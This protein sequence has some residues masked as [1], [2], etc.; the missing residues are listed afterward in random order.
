VVALMLA[1]AWILASANHGFAT[2]W[3]IWLV[4]LLAALLV[5]LTRVHI[6]WLLAA[7]AALGW[8]HLI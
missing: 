7:G 6:L 3:P 8:F 1:T 4:T 2:A 5:W